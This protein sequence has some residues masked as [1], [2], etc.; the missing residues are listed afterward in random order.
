M[1]KL[2]YVEISGEM[3]NQ[4]STYFLVAREDQISTFNITQ[5]GHS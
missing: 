5:H 4:M 2:F 3:Y 1:I